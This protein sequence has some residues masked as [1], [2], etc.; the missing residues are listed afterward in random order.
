MDMV[1]RSVSRRQFVLLAGAAAI[2]LFPSVR[3]ARADLSDVCV[4]EAGEGYT[5]GEFTRATDPRHWASL[6]PAIQDMLDGLVMFGDENP[7]A[8]S[9]SRAAVGGSTW[10]TAFDGVGSSYYA[11]GYTTSVICPQLY[12][13]VAYEK[14]GTIYAYGEP[15]YKSNDNNIPGSGTVYLPA[16]TYNVTA[17]GYANVP[18]TGYEVSYHRAYDTVDV[19]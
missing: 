14:G 3:N 13:Q 2:S 4:L 12:L 11:C 10:L 9:M 17:L 7:S 15:F 16:G 6:D 8:S 19:S 18:P 1:N 5:W